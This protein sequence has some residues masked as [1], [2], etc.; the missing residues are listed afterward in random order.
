M[1]AKSF[2]DHACAHPL[3]DQQH[4]VF[5]AMDSSNG[6]ASLREQSSFLQMQLQKCG[7]YLQRC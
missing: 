7:F 4:I 3:S 6:V 2:V 1:A 5:Q